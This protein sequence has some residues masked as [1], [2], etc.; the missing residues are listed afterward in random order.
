M[1]W[2]H[3]PHGSKKTF[4]II[5]RESISICRNL[6]HLS[7]TARL[8]ARFG[9]IIRPVRLHIGISMIAD[10]EH[11]YQTFISLGQL[12]VHTQ[13]KRLGEQMN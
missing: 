5:K 4:C 1:A 7:D 12:T 10:V 2:A 8:D 3:P 13:H 11:R 9:Q 6:F